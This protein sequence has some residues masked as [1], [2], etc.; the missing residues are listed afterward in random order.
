MNGAMQRLDAREIFARRRPG[1]IALF[2]AA[3]LGLAL[4]IAL[5]IG[6]AFQAL[7]VGRTP[8]AG[9]A[10]LFAPGALL[11]AEALRL[12]TAGWGSLAATSA[13]LLCLFAFLL[14]LPLASLYVALA[15]AGK[16]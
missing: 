13:V 3:R 10:G 2:W 4:L 1:A 6:T 12:G 8:E 5:P 7:G 15:H 11:L 14:L 16:L 9:D